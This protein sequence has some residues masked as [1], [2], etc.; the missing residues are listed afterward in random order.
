MELS[1]PK[2]KRLLILQEGTYKAP[3]ANKKFAL[4]KFLVSVKL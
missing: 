4:K 1:S 2:L 3:K